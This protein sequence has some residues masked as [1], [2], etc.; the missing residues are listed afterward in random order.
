M[1][2]K[3][4]NWILKVLFCFLFVFS[5]ISF[6]ANEWETIFQNLT[7]DDQITSGTEYSASL[8]GANV[9]FTITDNNGKDDDFRDADTIKLKIDGNGVSLPEI[10][11]YTKDQLVEWSKDN[12][13]ELFQAIFGNAPDTTISGMTDSQ[14]ITQQLFSSVYATPEHKGTKFYSISNKD[15]VLKGQYDFLEIDDV[16]AKGTSGII[17]YEHRFKNHKRSSIGISVPYRQLSLDD[18]VD[19]KYNYISFLPFYKHRWYP[20]RALVEFVAQATFGL[21]YLKSSLFPDGGGFLTYGAGTGVKYAYAVNERV[22]VNTGLALHILKKSIPSDLVPDD[23]SWVA[24]ALSDIPTEINLTPSVGVYV[25]L[26]PDKLFFRGDLF[27][28]HQLQDDVASGFENQTVSI[29][30]LTYMFPKGSRISLGYKQSFEMKD[31]TDQSIILDFKIK[32]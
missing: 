28:T 17:G 26:V 21:T 31:V 32:W 30:G 25:V 24:E 22:S 19:S 13:D 5:R 9:T 3:H 7:V 6:A 2:I 18:N 14:S 12:M 1:K 8:Y 11:G 29:S 16:D 10:E 15:I 27:R 20:T 4:F 23:I